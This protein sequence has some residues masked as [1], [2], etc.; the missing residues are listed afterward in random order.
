MSETLRAATGEGNHEQ[1]ASQGPLS[2]AELKDFKN[3]TNNLM[4]DALNVWADLWAELEGPRF[5]LRQEDAGASGVMVKPESAEGGFEPSCGWNEFLEKMWVLRHY[6]D[7][8]KRLS[9][10]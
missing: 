8:T 6:L 1:V 3:V 9:Q 7:F 10:Q 5:C 2:T 4:Q